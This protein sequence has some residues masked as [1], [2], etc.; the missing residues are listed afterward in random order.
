LFRERARRREL[1]SL[2]EAVGQPVS[3]AA[4]GEATH[5]ETPPVE[6]PRPKGVREHGDGFQAYWRG[7][8]GKQQQQGGFTTAGEA[9]A[10]RTAEMEKVSKARS[11]TMPAISAAGG[12]DQMTPGQ[13]AIVAE[14]ALTS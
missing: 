2:L 7:A 3:G 4:L 1:Q 11:N 9:K 14:T 10:H 8:D 5:D 12:H 6:A 13:A